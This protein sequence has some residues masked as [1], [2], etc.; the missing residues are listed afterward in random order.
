MAAATMV[1]PAYQA[2]LARR[3]LRS[4]PAAISHVGGIGVA[5]R[6]SWPLVDSVEGL[7]SGNRGERS[8]LQGN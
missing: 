3:R 4:P 6:P 8:S 2:S 7:A 1:Q 5:S